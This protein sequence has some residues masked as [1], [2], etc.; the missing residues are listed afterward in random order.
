VQGELGLRFGF[1]PYLC[2]ETD[3]RAWRQINQQLRQSFTA[4]Q[5]INAA[6]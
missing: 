4:E 2:N 3:V 1:V 6:G 5:P